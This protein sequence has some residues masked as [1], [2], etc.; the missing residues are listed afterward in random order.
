MYGFILI[1]QI[2][3][4]NV[5]ET[6]VS[7]FPAPHLI[8]G[9]FSFWRWPKTGISIQTAHFSS[10]ASLGSYRLMIAQMEIKTT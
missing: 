5:L 1:Y 9:P 10:V 4:Q 6:R 3:H 2:L 7:S 8:T